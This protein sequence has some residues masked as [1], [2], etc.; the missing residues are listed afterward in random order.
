[1]ANTHIPSSS[2]DIPA[3]VLYAPGA[4][5]VAAEAG[6]VSTD[7]SGNTYAPEVVD[8]SSKGE[9]A[10]AVAAGKST[11]TVVKASPGRLGR[12]L[13]TTSGSNAMLIYD[14]A[15]G[16]TGMIIGAVAA[17]APIGPVESGFPAANGITV[18]GNASNPG[19]TI[20]FT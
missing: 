10:V 5:V 12:I 1:M 16:H 13:V 9:Q 14:N 6:L 2:N 15:S 18:Q 8:D 11:D 17:N 19:V 7:A 4:S 20:S 3:S